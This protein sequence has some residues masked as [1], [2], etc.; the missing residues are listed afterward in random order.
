MHNAGGSVHN[1]GFPG[2]GLH[3]GAGQECLQA[4]LGH[5]QRELI[6]HIVYKY[7]TISI[8]RC[9]DMDALIWMCGYDRII[10][11]LDQ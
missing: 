2:S 5:L 6:M 3:P 1:A 4:P 9:M 10:M 7:H 11:N 8:Y